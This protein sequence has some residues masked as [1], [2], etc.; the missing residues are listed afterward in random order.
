[1]INFVIVYSFFLM[2]Q[3]LQLYFK[4]ETHEFIH[5]P[6]L[7]Y[8]L[9]IVRS[10]DAGVYLI[11]GEVVLE[12]VAELVEFQKILMLLVIFIGIL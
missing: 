1:M 12:L 11:F 2:Y 9:E 3:L 10:M 7:L 8:D 6:H 5:P 4:G